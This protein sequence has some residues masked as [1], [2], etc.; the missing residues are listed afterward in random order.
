MNKTLMSKSLLVTILSIITQ[1]CAYIGVVHVPSDRDSQVWADAA[2]PISNITCIPSEGEAPSEMTEER[3]EEFW[4]KP[5][6]VDVIGGEH[7]YVYEK[8]TTNWSGIIIVAMLPIPLVLPSAKDECVVQLEN[9]GIKKLEKRTQARE[10]FYGCGTYYDLSVT[11][12][13]RYGC[14]DRIWR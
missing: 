8:P 9:D 11:G 13:W 14:G 5:D 10:N 4:G 2:L 6:R 12:R 1:G 3:L 7:F